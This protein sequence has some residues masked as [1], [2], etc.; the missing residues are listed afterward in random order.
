MA[1]PQRKMISGL[2][3]ATFTPLNDQGEINPSVIE[4]YVDYL[5]KEQGVRAVFVNGTTGESMSLSVEERKRLAEE[6]CQRGKGKLD[7]VI[8]HV[9]CLSLKE[10]QELARHAADVGADGI[11]V[12]SPCFFKPADKDALR[13]FLQHVAKAAPCLPFYYYHL[14]ALT[15]VSF[16]AMD[17][18]QGIEDII[19]SFQGLKF[20][21][22][23]LMDF[24]Q[25][26]HHS[27]P[28]WPMLYGMDEQ[29]LAALVMGAHGAVG[30]TYNYMGCV[31]NRLLEAYEKGDYVLARSIQF[32]TQEVISYAVKQGFDTAVNKQLMCVVSGLP[33]GP[34][35]LPL[36]ECPRERALAIARRLQEV[37]GRTEEGALETQP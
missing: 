27:P 31:V 35:R 26:V 22:S 3:A 5:V 8:V 12:I 18:L 37:L 14:P 29:L 19:P 20:S 33:L 10:S 7:Q 21:G 32:Q 6:W 11:A 28:H 30:S 25:C 34:P 24:G 36:Q 15:G 9:G 16:K 17:I 13:K 4:R 23:D 1:A 2:I